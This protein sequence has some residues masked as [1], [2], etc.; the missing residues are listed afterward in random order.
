MKEITSTMVNPTIKKL[1]SYATLEEK[2][3]GEYKNTLVCQV[4]NYIVLK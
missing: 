4:G 3:D 1:L 2:V